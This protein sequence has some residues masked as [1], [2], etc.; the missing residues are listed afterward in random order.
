MRQLYEDNFKSN[1]VLIM[2]AVKSLINNLDRMK[3]AVIYVV[4]FFV[5]ISISAQSARF[6]YELGYGTYGMKNM[7]DIQNQLI[8]TYSPLPIKSVLQFPGYYNHTFSLD[9]YL[10][11]NVLF[12]INTTYLTTGGRD[13]L[14]DYSGEYKADILLKAYQFGLESEYTER[15]DRNLDIF[16]NF[17]IGVIHSDLKITENIVVYHV[18]SL[19]NNSNYDEWSPFVEPTIGFSYSISKKI[20][21]KISIGANVDTSTNILIDWSGLRTRIGIAY[22]L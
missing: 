2:G 9:Y 20:Q 1:R 10:S 19:T 6:S 5:S 18:D 8:K 12:G 17:K 7:K 14:K 15:I 16:F 21:A 13:H 11:D 3:N 4:L 22:S